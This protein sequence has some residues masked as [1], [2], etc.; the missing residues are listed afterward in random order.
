LAFIVATAGA[1]GTPFVAEYLDYT[2]SRPE[3]LESDLGVPVLLTVPKVA[4]RRLTLRWS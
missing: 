4:S 2:Y 1:L 3:Q